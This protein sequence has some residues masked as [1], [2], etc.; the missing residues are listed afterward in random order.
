MHCYKNLHFRVASRNMRNYAQVDV[1]LNCE[2][3]LRASLNQDL[4]R[5]HR[6]CWS[7]IH[8]DLYHKGHLM[9][10]H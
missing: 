4:A 9:N 7:K 6:S 5:S 2:A 10:S 8:Y 1:Y 3:I